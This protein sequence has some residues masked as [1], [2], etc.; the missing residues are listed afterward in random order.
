MIDGRNTTLKGINSAVPVKVKKA[1]PLKSTK[2]SVTVPQEKVSLSGVKTDKVVKS[3]SE[4][5]ENKC[6]EVSKEAATSANEAA[7]KASRSGWKK[8][9]GAGLLLTTAVAAAGLS[10]GCASTGMG[11]TTY[12]PYTGASMHVEVFDDGIYPGYHRQQDYN[13]GYIHGRQDQWMQE[14]TEDMMYGPDVIYQP[15]PTII[16]QPVPVYMG[17]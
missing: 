10:S 12:D 5:A 8:K 6:G 15:A 1:Q 9:V 3:E 17:W 13:S 14:R 11:I 2:E 7:E 4:I 16:Y